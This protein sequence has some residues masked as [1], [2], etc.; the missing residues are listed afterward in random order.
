[1]RALFI[2]RAAKMFSYASLRPAFFLPEKGEW[3]SELK[4]EWKK[5]NEKTNFKKDPKDPKKS[6]KQEEREKI[7]DRSL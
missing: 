1:M 4:S 7:P 2:S 6:E 5:A 3:K